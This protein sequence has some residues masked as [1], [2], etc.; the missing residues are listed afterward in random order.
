[1]QQGRADWVKP[2]FMVEWRSTGGGKDGWLRG[3]IEKWQGGHS[4]LVTVAKPPG[5]EWPDFLPEVHYSPS[6]PTPH[7]VHYPPLIVCAISPLVLCTMHPRPVHYAPLTMCTTR[8]IPFSL[9]SGHPLP[10]S[11]H[12]TI[13]GENPNQVSSWSHS[14]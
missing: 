1:M 13:E 6:L 12:A 8:T 11:D 14:G 3:K 7:H 9:E 10:A 5:V 2:G 4:N